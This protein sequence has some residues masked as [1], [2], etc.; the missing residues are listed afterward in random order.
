MATTE[1]PSEISVHLEYQ[2]TLPKPGAEVGQIR[3]WIPVPFDD[4][5]Q[6]LSEIEL[7]PGAKLVRD[8]DT[9]N[10]FLFLGYKPSTDL[11]EAITCRFHVRRIAHKP[12][13]DSTPQPLTDEQRER[14][15]VLKEIGDIGDP[16]RQLV[17]DVVGEA[18]GDLPT[19]Q[20]IYKYVFDN[21][22]CLPPGPA[23]YGKASFSA[24]KDKEGYPSDLAAVLVG[25]CR[26]QGVPARLESGLLIDP[27]TS[28][29]Q[30]GCYCWSWFYS[31]RLGWTPLDVG[32]AQWRSAAAAKAGNEELES[33]Q[34]RAGFGWLDSFRIAL[35][36]GVNVDVPGG[37]KQI[38]FIYNPL[39]LF[40]DQVVAGDKVHSSWNCLEIKTSP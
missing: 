25:L 10:R 34:M 13:L 2:L 18:D 33:A 12:R 31:E 29:V 27:Q 38:R 39:V 32:V 22:K 35:G 3:V 1:L 30:P 23:E 19:V 9:G 5:F 26:M 4:R 11:P 36:R 40:D 7:P 15:L 17:A 24:L 8:P 21:L 37:P 16:A 6:R 28:Q 20:R 14:F